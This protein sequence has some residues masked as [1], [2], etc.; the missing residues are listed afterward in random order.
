MRIHE[1]LDQCDGVIRLRDHRPAART[2]HRAAAVG[3]VTPILPGIYV[4]A[5]R[6][7]AASI[8]LRAACAWSSTGV[9]H[10]R[11]AAE[12]HLRQPVSL[13]IRLRARH[14]GEH[15]APWLQVSVGRVANPLV[16]GDFRVATAAHSSVELA[17]TDGGEAIFEMLRR[18]V[19]VPADLADVRGEFAGT[20]GNRVRATVVAAAIDNPWSFGELRLHEVLRKARI[21]GWVANRPLRVGGQYVIPDVWFEQERLVL[22]FDGEAVHTTH[23]QFEDDRRRQNLLVL[24]RCRVLRFTWE[25]VT[26]RPEDVVRTVRAALETHSNVAMPHPDGFW[27]TEFG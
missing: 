10:G 6:A 12:L 14:R 22:E 24:G 11:T 23:E 19:I 5:E 25:A 17:A 18:R 2:V 16:S 8:R 15:V 20:P 26:R 3:V 9:I 21:A 7:T 4:S 27:S 13:P 1:L